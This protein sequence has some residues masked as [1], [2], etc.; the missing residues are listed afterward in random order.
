MDLRAIYEDLVLIN[1]AY[2]EVVHQ[3]A[4]SHTPNPEAA[5]IDFSTV[6]RTR[7][8]KAYRFLSSTYGPW[9]E[10]SSVVFYAPRLFLDLSKGANYTRL[11][12]R[13]QSL[14]LADETVLESLIAAVAD[15][16]KEVEHGILTT[17]GKSH[18]G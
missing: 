9:Y 18:A 6:E 10:D 14:L 4:L 8:S 17:G 2:G 3:V 11:R 15:E 5:H 13:L 7:Y 1:N 16:I 12:L